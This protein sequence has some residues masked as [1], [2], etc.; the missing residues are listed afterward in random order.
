VTVGFAPQPDLSTDSAADRGELP[1]EQDD[2]P[3]CRHC[4][5]NGSY[6]V[7]TDV[8]DEHEVDC[9][10]CSDLDD[11]PDVDR[12]DARQDW[13]RHEDSFQRDVD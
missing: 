12:D 13:A 8:D 9:E 7:Q 3:A 6:M 10:H 4:D 2:E 11:G 1:L 5:G